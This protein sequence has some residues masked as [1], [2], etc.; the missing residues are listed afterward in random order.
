MQY[1]YFIIQEQDIFHLFY[2]PD[3]A[4][5]GRSTRGKCHD[6]M[7][8]GTLKDWHLF[9]TLISQKYRFLRQ[10]HILDKHKIPLHPPYH[11]THF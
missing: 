7:S 3:D 5:E 9:C 11:A 8:H 10:R 2:F 4:V 6:I 1:I